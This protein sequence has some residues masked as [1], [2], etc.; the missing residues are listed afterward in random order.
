VAPGSF[1]FGGQHLLID[2]RT[3][4][5]PIDNGVP[6]NIVWCLFRL[7]YRRPSLIESSKGLQRAIF[8]HCVLDLF[9]DTGGTRKLVPKMFLVQCTVGAEQRY[10]TCG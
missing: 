4:I 9:E 3:R 5:D 2:F 7:S 1:D 10:R 8:G 6:F